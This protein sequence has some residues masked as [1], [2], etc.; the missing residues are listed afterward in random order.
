MTNRRLSQSRV[1]PSKVGHGRS[2][3]VLE[4][5]AQTWIGLKRIAIRRESFPKKRIKS[6]LSH[7][8]GAARIHEAQR[9]MAGGEKRA[10]CRSSHT[11]TLHRA[12]VSSA[13]A[14]VAPAK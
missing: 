7:A 14:R 12:W 11:S 4:F 1:P 8:R 13:S 5:G 9:L 10:S 2:S 6:R 3:R